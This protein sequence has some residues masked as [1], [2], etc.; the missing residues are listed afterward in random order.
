MLK[1][2]IEYDPVENEIEIFDLRDALKGVF[3]AV[4]IKP[5]K[6]HDLETLF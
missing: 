2:D 3:G 6:Q 1:L 4:D 5:L